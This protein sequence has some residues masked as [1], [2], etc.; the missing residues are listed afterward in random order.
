MEP[1]R[2]VGVVK[3]GRW[4]PRD[5]EQWPAVLSALQRWT[6]SGRAL[7]YNDEGVPVDIGALQGTSIVCLDARLE[8]YDPEL[9]RV[10]AAS[11]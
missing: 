4:T 5:P 3:F 2:V 7:L 10:W 1:K 8:V 9:W 11:R 6:A